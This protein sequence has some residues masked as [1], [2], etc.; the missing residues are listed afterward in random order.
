MSIVNKFI[1]SA[2]FLTATA[3]YDDVNLTIKA[4]D[5]FYQFGGQSREQVSGLLQSSVICADCFTTDN[6]DYVS[7]N[8]SD[9][10]CLTQT[11]T[12][13]Y[14]PTGLTFTNT[15]NIFTDVNLSTIAADGW[16]SEPN[17][18]SYRQMS[19][20]VLGAVT[21]CPGCYVG[22][23]LDYNTTANNLCCISQT[24]GSYFIDYG[25]TFAT[26][27][28]VYS[29]NIGTPATDGFY[30]VNG[31]ST[32][33]E[34]AGGTLAAAAACPTCGTPCG[35]I[36]IPSGNQGVYSLDINI[37]STAS[38]VGATVVYFDPQ[39]IPDGIRVLYD[40]TYYNAVAATAPT[41]GRIKTTSL[42]NNAFTILGTSNSCVPTAP[43]TTTYNYYDSISGS[44]WVQ[45]GT[46]SE[47]INVGDAQF[48]GANSFSAIVIPKPNQLPASLTVD[49]LGPCTGTIFQLDVKCPE[50]LHSF[51]SSFN[52]SN[53]NCESTTQ[54]YYFAKNYADRNN[55]A[56]VYP[57]LGNWV[58]NDNTG[59]NI[60][61]DGYYK[62]GNTKYI[63]TVNGVVVAT[64]NCTGPPP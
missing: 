42:V 43:N 13:Y 47:T 39:G 41:P 40:G 8:E 10:C 22:V 48:G 33:R 45:N 52:S 44:S 11:A 14:F 51:T 5:G 28:G 38:D 55:S 24:S 46:V 59:T 30:Q 53:T 21:A 20:S 31:T 3:V 9:L 18:N 57:T 34:Q 1:D 23:T 26:T 56:I 49:V 62:M 19:G 15:T 12:L 2:D 17:G 7:T 16:Y 25:T 29:D 6:L 54:I 27:S 37:G 64:G 61:L 36:N 35:A 32:Y 50:P 4:A 63:Q 58:F 60:L